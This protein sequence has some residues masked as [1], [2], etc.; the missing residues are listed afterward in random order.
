MDR[1]SANFPYLYFA[2]RVGML[3]LTLVALAAW[4]ITGFNVMEGAVPIIGIQW[5]TFA[6]FT[7]F[8]YLLMVNFQA[9]GLNHFSDL[10]TNFKQDLGFL[11]RVFRHP[12][13]IRDAY[14]NQGVLDGIRAMLLSSLICLG[15][16]F[17]FEAIWVPLYDYFQF[18][19][20]MWPVYMASMPSGQVS[21]LIRNM[22]LGIFPLALMPLALRLLSLD[23]PT[24][25]RFQVKWRLD[26][27]LVLLMAIGFAFWGLWITFPHQAMSTANLAASQVMGLTSSSFSLTNCY[28]WPSQ[29]FFPQNTYT[30][31]PCAVQGTSYTLPQIMGF[32]NPDNW[33]HLVN[34]LTKF[35][36][37]AAICY[38]F[39]AI[40]RRNE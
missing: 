27:G 39:M 26:S 37:F 36:T 19:S 8:Y 29:G 30:F 18:G 11:G 35:C 13:G 32:F 34:V 3:G 38:P 31:Y 33:L 20:V 4:G 1:A 2:F 25:D 7:F 15:A 24:K 5:S 14:P 10:K 22:V 23:S 17:L 16:L 28:V 9:G 40:V 6:T 12:K 21:P